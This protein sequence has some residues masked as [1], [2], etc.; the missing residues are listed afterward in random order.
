[1][2]DGLFIGVM[3]CFNFFIVSVGGDMIV[4][5]NKFILVVKIND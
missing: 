1:V 5:K 2:L 3:S 4:E